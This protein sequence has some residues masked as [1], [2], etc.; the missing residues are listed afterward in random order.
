VYQNVEELGTSEHPLASN[1]ECRPLQ[2]LLFM[3]D[4]VFGHAA[5]VFLAGRSVVCLLLVSCC[6]RFVDCAMIW[7]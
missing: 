1:L 5:R 2:S 6:M 4:L 7:T 3:Y